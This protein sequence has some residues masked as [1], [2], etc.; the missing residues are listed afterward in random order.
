MTV[1]VQELKKRYAAMPDEDFRAVERGDLTV[2]ARQCYDAELARRDPARL[3]EVQQQDAADA[4][5][6]TRIAAADLDDPEPKQ[7]WT[8]QALLVMAWLMTAVGLIGIAFRFLNDQP[9]PGTLLGILGST[10]SAWSIPYMSYRKARAAWEARRREAGLL[11]EPQGDD[12]E[13][14]LTYG[15]ST[16]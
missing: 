7:G 8:F 16:E 15:E 4:E 13:E 1:D 3:R 5:L 10:W 9:I 11:S 2:A 6:R 14:G 12:Q